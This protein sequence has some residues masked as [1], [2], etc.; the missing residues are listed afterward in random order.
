QLRQYQT[1]DSL[2]LILWKRL[3]RDSFRPIVRL[4][5]PIQQYDPSWV[6]IA[7]LSG[8]ALEQALSFGC[9]KLL[10]LEADKQIYGL[11]T[12][13]VTYPPSQGALH[14]QRC[15]QHLALYPCQ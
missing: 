6:T 4:R 11:K 5:E 13:K 15:L 3:A 7:D 12:S 9:E 14:L 2:N 8:A 1:G 10:T